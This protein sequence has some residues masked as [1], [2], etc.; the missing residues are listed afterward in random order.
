MAKLTNKAVQKE[1][2]NTGD[3]VTAVRLV[4]FEKQPNLIAFVSVVYHDI[5]MN[6]ITVKTNQNDDA[7]IQ[8]PA[9]QRF[10]KD[11]KEVIDGGFKVY[12]DIMGPATKEARAEILEMVVKAVEAK[13]AEEQAA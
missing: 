1:E 12:D 5:F 4:N 13:M 8:F 2:V 7:Y 10:D 6:N 11:K 9:K 3:R